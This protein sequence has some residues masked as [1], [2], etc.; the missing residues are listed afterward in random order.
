ME[1]LT[2]FLL[3]KTK[4]LH[5]VILNKLNPKK[6]RLFDLAFLVLKATK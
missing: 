1:L 3:L 4:E 2:A 5:T 6:S